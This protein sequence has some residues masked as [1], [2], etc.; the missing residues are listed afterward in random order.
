MII[1]GSRMYGKKNQVH[2]HGRCDHCGTYGKME[3][4]NGRKWGHL[5][6]IPLIP[7][8]G[9]ARVLRECKACNMG[10]HIPEENIAKILEDLRANIDRAIIAIGA[11]ETHFELGGEQIHATGAILNS[12]NDFYC[13]AGEEEIN[14]LVA[15]LQVA[16]ADRHIRITEAKLHEIRGNHQ[17]AD[18]IYS[19]LMNGSEE[20]VLLLHYAQYMFDTGRFEQAKDATERL[21]RLEPDAVMVKLMLIDCHANLKEFRPAVEI[22]ESLFETVP[23]LRED[24]ASYKN[25]KKLCKK[26]GVTPQKRK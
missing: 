9:P 15:N 1:Y 14:A 3:S 17:E 13:L 22:Y 16:Q 7:S 12:I 8:G 23:E 18:G 5:Y 21:L 25:Y 24:K 10:S 19:E 20:S 2:S 11:Q 4:Y 6:F 26:A